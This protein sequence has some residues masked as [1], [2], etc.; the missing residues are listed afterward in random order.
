MKVTLSRPCLANSP[1]IAPNQAPGLSDTGTQDS[2]AQAT[3]KALFN[4]RGTS[5]PVRAA[6]TN[7]K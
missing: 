1:K 7:P 6:G 2:Q 5:N 4:S 3:I